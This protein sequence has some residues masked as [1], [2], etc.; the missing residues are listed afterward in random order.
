VEVHDRGELTGAL[1]V[2]AGIVGVNNRDL[3]TMNVDLETA[4][5]LA[6]AAFRTT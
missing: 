1:G 3:K 5:G 2:G 4:L 6:A